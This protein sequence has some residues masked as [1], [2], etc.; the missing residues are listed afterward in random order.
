M[1]KRL[2]LAALLGLFLSMPLFAAKP[3]VIAV[4]DPLAK[5]LA[6][7]CIAGFAQRNYRALATHLKQTGNPA[8]ADIE[9]IIAG[10]LPAAIRKSSQQRVDM[11]I[12]IDSVVR[13]ELQKAKMPATAIA[14][15]TNKQGEITFTGL[16]VVAA[17]DPAKSIADL[18]QHRILLGPPEY[19]ERYAA[20][21]KL[22]AK[23]GI[24][25]HDSASASEGTNIVPRCSEAAFTILENESPQPI[26]AV[27]SDYNLLL[28]EGCK[29]IETGALRVLGK[30]EPV[31][32]ISVFVT[33]TAD[34]RTTATLSQALRVLAPRDA[35]LL[36]AL[37]SKEG[38][39]PYRKEARNGWEV[40]PVTKDEGD[41]KN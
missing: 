35:R 28:L 25:V 32:F 29:T 8:F 3:F 19:D 9:L 1:I 31:P 18:K 7:D 40:F 10:S 21:I 26:A 23:H 36:A 11:V 27:I 30:T 2:L 4:A 14:W 13:A 41:S 34:P 38:F 16:V 37:E 5:E 15:L 20:A 22:F 12:G 33:E 39:V 6:C 17:D 24:T